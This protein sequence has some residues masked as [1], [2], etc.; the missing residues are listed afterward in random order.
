MQPVLTSYVYIKIVRAGKKKKKDRK[1]QLVLFSSYC[2]ALCLIF[3][4]SFFNYQSVTQYT[5]ISICL[6]DLFN[7]ELS[8]ERFWWG[9]RSREVGRADQGT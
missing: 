5:C 1:I 7:A 6:L 8:P 3:T 9:P 4:W 2:F